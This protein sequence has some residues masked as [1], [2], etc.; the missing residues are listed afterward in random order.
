MYILFAVPAISLATIFTI[1]LRNHFAQ[2][3]NV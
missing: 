3:T 1:S 2:F